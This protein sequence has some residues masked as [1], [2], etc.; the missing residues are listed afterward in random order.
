MDCP[1]EETLVRMKLE[2]VPE[3][4]KLEFDLQEHLL[5]IYHE[6]GEKNIERSLLDLGMGGRKI[7]SGPAALPRPGKY[8]LQRKVL[9][10]V[11]GI[12]FFFF[13]LEMSAGLFS[14]SMGL[15]ADSL[16]MLADAFVYGISIFAI[17]GT[18]LR[19][20]RVAAVAGYFQISLALAG[21]AEVVRRVLGDTGLPD[22]RMMIGIS[23]LAL[24]ANTVCLW[25]LQRTDGQEEAHIKASMIFTS[26]DVIVNLGV[27]LAAVLIS[28]LD[29]GLPDLIIGTV[30]FFL[31]MRGA[32][33]ILT[34]GR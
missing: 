6:G 3:V 28:V 27:I 8:T 13:L 31:V 2:K 21:F 15:M 5:N 33:R 23:F 7:R 9:W 17:G 19:K 20:K 16:D 11:L 30:V 10:A 22:V 1:S 24:I 26:N 25:L 4:K 12:N 32:V 18:A 29:T 34:L 14:G